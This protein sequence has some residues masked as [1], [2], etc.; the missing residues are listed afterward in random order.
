MTTSKIAVTVPDEVLSRAREAVRR[1]RSASLSAYVS[2]ALDQK[3]MQDELDDL[4]QEMLT[5]TGGPLSPRELERAEKALKVP[6]RAR[7]RK[8]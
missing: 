7:A 4:L 2:A 3:L 5:E 1:G 8:A 6:Q